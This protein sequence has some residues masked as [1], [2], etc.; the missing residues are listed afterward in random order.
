MKNLRVPLSLLLL[1]LVTLACAVTDTVGGVADNLRGVTNLWDDVPRM[2]GLTASDKDLP[3]PVK[4]IIR[5]VLAQVIGG[6]GEGNSGDWILF[7]TDKTSD[8]VKA[9][10]TN[11][12]MAEHGW[13]NSD[14]ST[15]LDG[16]DQGVTQ[17]GAVCVFQKQEGNEYTG[18]LILSMA[19]E[20]AGMTN[21]IFVRVEGEQTPSPGTTS[22]AP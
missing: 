8:D 18:L 14:T 16:S 7:T 15:C 11:E 4:L 17:V 22:N 19:A 1:V 10:Y 2:E 3:L 12:L 5:T 20:E 13:E 6:G 21:V 9:F